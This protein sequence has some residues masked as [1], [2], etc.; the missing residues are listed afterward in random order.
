MVSWVQGSAAGNRWAGQALQ[1]SSRASAAATALWV[2]PSQHSCLASPPLAHAAPATHP[3]LPRGAGRAAPCSPGPTPSGA[4]AAARTRCGC[5]QSRSCRCWGPQSKRPAGGRQGDTG[6]WASGLSGGLATTCTACPPNTAQRRELQ[7]AAPA[8]PLPPHSQ[9]RGARPVALLALALSAA[10]STISSAA[11]AGSWGS[12]GTSEYIWGQQGGKQRL[13]CEPVSRRVVQAGR[14][15]PN[16][17]VPL[18][19]RVPAGVSA[20]P[21]STSPCRSASAA[22]QGAPGSQRRAA[23]GSRTWPQK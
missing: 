9:R 18:S 5:P 11:A 16:Q 10:L 13:G 14:A 8:R 22:Q 1:L 6:G 3:R 20:T 4:S 12:W 21:R 2:A 15:A 17:L 19:R 7:R 23:A